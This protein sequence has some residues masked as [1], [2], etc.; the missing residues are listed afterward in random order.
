MAARRVL[1]WD[2]LDQTSRLV[3]EER[4]EMARAERAARS[5]ESGDVVVCGVG[6]G[7]V[8]PY[9]VGGGSSRWHRDALWT[10]LQGSRQ[11][12]QENALWKKVL[13][14]LQTREM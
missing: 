5:G 2:P 4:F 8:R 3:V 7:T 12:R 10:R 14:S 1:P 9:P 11:T 13:V 6:G